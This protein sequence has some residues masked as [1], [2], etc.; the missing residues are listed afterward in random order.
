MFYVFL[1][2]FKAYRIQST[3]FNDIADLDRGPE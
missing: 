1:K 3:I 2:H